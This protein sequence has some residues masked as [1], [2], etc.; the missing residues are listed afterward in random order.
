MIWTH[1][2]LGLPT[3][4]TLDQTAARVQSAFTIV[5]LRAPPAST[6]SLTPALH[7]NTVSAPWPPIGPDAHRIFFAVLRTHMAPP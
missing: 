3:A 5:P 7:R 1:G 6:R 4:G 2:K